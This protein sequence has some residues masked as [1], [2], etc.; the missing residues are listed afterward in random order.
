MMDSSFFILDACGFSVL[1]T[2]LILF[3]TM[4]V[5]MDSLTTS[6]FVLVSLIPYFIILSLVV[7][8]EFLEDMILV[9]DL[10]YPVY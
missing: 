1:L 10:L 3:F 7:T 5:V 9:L 2:G 8:N 6:G 4:E